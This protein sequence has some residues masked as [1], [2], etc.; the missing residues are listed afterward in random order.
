MLGHV[1]R[2]CLGWVLGSGPRVAV[3]VGRARRGQAE[4]LGVGVL[5]VDEH[6][7]AAGAVSR[8]AAME[9]RKPAAQCTH[10]GRSGSSSR[11]S[12]SAC[13]G[14]CGEPGI[15]TRGALVVTAYVEHD[16]AVA[17]L[18]GAASTA[19]PRSARRGRTRLRGPR[20][21]APRPSRRPSRRAGR[22]RCAPAGAGRRRRRRRT[23]ADQRQRGAP[24]DQPAEVGGELAAELDADAAGDVGLRRRAVRPRRSTTHSPRAIRS[25]NAP[26]STDSGGLRSAGPGPARFR[27]AMW[28]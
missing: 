27:G 2:P 12:S 11:R 4:L 25:R 9:A 8:L 26:G 6:D 28:A 3:E 7:V 21:P 20:R 1:E 24:R 19:G 17:S 15:A 5:V 13:I 23:L 22:C 10:S 14:T 16:R 18:V